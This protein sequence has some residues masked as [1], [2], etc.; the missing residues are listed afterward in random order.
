MDQIAGFPLV[1]DFPVPG[2]RIRSFAINDIN[3]LRFRYANFQVI[4]PLSGID[5]VF[6]GSIALC[7]TCQAYRQRVRVIFYLC[8][9]SLRIDLVAWEAGNEIWNAETMIGVD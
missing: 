2:S 8:E 3:A 5:S 7:Y 6:E 1:E 9:S 4:A